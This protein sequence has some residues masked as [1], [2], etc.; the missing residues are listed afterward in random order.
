MPVEPSELSKLR[1]GSWDKTTDLGSACVPT[2]LL[3][4]PAALQIWLTLSHLKR[5]NFQ[6]S[7][8]H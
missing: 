6:P 1:L 4:F 3:V 8:E 7:C 2:H 5:C